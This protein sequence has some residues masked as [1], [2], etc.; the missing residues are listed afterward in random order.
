LKLVERALKMSDQ[1]E[2]VSLAGAAASTARTT[3]ARCA[4]GRRWS[5]NGRRTAY[6]PQVQSS[7]A[8]ARERGGLGLTGSPQARRRRP[9]PVAT[10]KPLAAPGG[11]AA[12]LPRRRR[13]SRPLAHPAWNSAAGAG[14]GQVGR[15]TDTV[16]IY[17]R[18]A[19]ARA[20][21]WAILRQA[22]SRTCRRTSR[23]TKH[24]HVAGGE[25]VAVCQGVVSARVS[26]GGQ[27]TASAGDLVGQSAPWA[28][29]PTVS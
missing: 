8:Q 24:G 2:G 16:F 5:R 6:L 12:R 1:P 22:G 17:A 10:A 25:A 15:T 29:R 23:S 18:P 7:I 11:K 14:A 13:L 9:P 20:G 21:R 3:P 4:T 28:R 19:R 27:A 26:K